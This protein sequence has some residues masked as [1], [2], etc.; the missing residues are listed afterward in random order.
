M[1]ITVYVMQDDG[2]VYQM[3]EKVPV[4]TFDGHLIDVNNIF[5]F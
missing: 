2:E 3:G 4:H 1:I 5:D